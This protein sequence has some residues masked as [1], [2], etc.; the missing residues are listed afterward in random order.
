MG[1]PDSACLSGEAGS[2]M[3]H[4]DRVFYQMHLVAVGFCFNNIYLALRKAACASLVTA[5][6]CC[7]SS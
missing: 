7:F 2:E 6:P 4:G 3:L 5:S 1:I